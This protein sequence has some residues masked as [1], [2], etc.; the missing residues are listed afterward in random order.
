MR[1]P[2]L[3]A[4][5]RLGFVAAKRDKSRSFAALRM[6]MHLS[7]QGHSVFFEDNY[8]L[9]GKGCDGLSVACAV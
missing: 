9:A 1:E 3:L 2:L 7:A 4:G 6:T 8:G 5:W